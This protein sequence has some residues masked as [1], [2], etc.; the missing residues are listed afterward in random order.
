MVPDTAMCPGGCSSLSGGRFRKDS[1]LQ[2]SPAAGKTTPLPRDTKS[3]LPD[4]VSPCSITP[5]APPCP[6]QRRYLQCPGVGR[7]LIFITR[8]RSIW[9]M[10]NANCVCIDLA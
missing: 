4:A 6:Q 7:R 5:S 10:N 9:N 1:P 2:P 8:E 3:A